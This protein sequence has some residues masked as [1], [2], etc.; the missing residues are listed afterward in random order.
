MLAKFSKMS[1][2][3]AENYLPEKICQM[4]EDVYNRVIASY[5]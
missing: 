4:H 2:R 1:H 3:L 5:W